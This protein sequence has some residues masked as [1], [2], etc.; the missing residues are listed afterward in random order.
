[1]RSENT[2]SIKAELV[3]IR[4][5][6]DEGF[7][8]GQFRPECRTGSNG[9]RV[10]KADH[11]AGLGKMFRPEVGMNY[12]LHGKYSIHPRFGRQFNFDRYEVIKPKDTN[13]I[14]RYLVRVAKYVG[15]A[16]ADRLIETYGSETLEVLEA[17]PE[18]VAHE[19]SGLTCEKAK[20]IAA[21]LSKDAKMRAVL[22][23]LEAILDIPGLRKDLPVDVVEK[24]G[25]DAA[26]RLKDNPY[27]LTQFNR[28]GFQTADAIALRKLKIEPDSIFRITAASRHIMKEQMMAAGHIWVDETVYYQAMKD[29][30]SIPINVI[31]TSKKE[32]LANGE[33]VEYEQLLALPSADQ[34]ETY[35]ANKIYYLSP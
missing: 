1:M 20:G 30:L 14:F 34:D 8:I 19:I 17:D 35:I 25:S 22:V 31:K 26:E 27:L 28:V 5:K 15:P 13:G 32:L 16:V 18:K 2:T 10:N 21:A 29:L 23:E 12:V 4:F 7:L 11:L 33:I 9:V 6:S 24:Y 3:N